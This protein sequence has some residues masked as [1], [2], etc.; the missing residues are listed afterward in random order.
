MTRIIIEAIRPEQ[1]RLAVY[2]EEGC[3]DWSWQPNGDLLVTVTS[4]GDSD[5]IDRSE[6]FLIAFHEM[7]E[8][9]LCR[10]AGVP[11]AA[12][13]AFDMNYEGEAEPGSHPDAPYF[14]QH[15]AA[16]ILESMLAVLLGRYDWAVE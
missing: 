3:G 2:R 4:R 5:V 10:H 8:A 9:F 16:C 1:A 7:V 13:D 14:R 15:K 11:Q 12:V 6:L